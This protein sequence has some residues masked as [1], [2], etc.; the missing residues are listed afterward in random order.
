MADDHL[1]MDDDSAL[2]QFRNRINPADAQ[3]LE[4]SISK[5]HKNNYFD[6]LAGG[7][8]FLANVNSFS[9]SAATFVKISR[10]RNEEDPHLS[11]TEATEA[12]QALKEM[13]MTAR[14]LPI[15]Q[16]VRAMG[17]MMG[18]EEQDKIMPKVERTLDMFFGDNVE[19][20]LENVVDDYDKLLSDSKLMEIMELLEG[21]SQTIM[22]SKDLELR[23]KAVESMGVLMGKL[24]ERVM[25]IV[26]KMAAQMNDVVQDIMTDV[27]PEVENEKE[28]KEVAE[29]VA[30]E[31]RKKTE[32]LDEENQKFT[33]ELDDLE[34]MLG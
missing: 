5:V 31:K 33:E 7:S 8:E 16:M 6:R 9:K 29:R 1:R 21:T 23:G 17:V 19:N 13:M 32:K 12:K 11:S 25:P 10:K 27:D 4:L 20:M 18:D 3:N 30:E 22:E 34:N 28:E 24:T 14:A 2:L 15:K 26:M